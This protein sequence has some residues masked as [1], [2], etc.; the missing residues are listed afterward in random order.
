VSGNPPG[1]RGIFISYRRSD[2]P[3]AAR[4]LKDRLRERFP[5]AAVYFDVDQEPGIDWEARIRE[6]GRN[7]EVFLV[8]IGPRWISELTARSADWRSTGV[9]DV[10]RREIQWAL[11]D[12][13]GV[14]VPV[15]VETGMPNERDLPR[16][17]KGL[18]RK[19]AVVNIRH[20]TFDND[21]DRLLA[22]LEQLS[23]A[24]G[25]ARL[26]ARDGSGEALGGEPS[27]TP[28]RGAAGVPVPSDDHYFEVVGEMTN[29]MVVPLLGASVRGAPPDSCFLAQ[30]LADQFAELRLQSSDL[31]EIAQSIAMMKSDR[32]LRTKLR[33]LIERYSEPIDVHRFLACFPGLFRRGGLPAPYQ[34]IIST[35]YDR[36]LERAFEAVDEPFEYVIY[37]PTSGRFVHFPWGED[38]DEP[39][40]ITIDDPG[41]YFGFEMGENFE[42]QRTLIV[43]LHG[44]P[45]FWEA[46]RE[47]PDDY[48]VTE[49]QYIDYL[50]TAIAGAHLPAEI[51]EKLTGSRC[52][53]LG[54]TLREW[55]TRV[56]LRR[57]WQGMQIRENSWVIEDTPDEL[58]KRSWGAIPRVELFDAHPSEYVGRLSSA[59]DVRLGTVTP[60]GIAG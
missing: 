42:L 49:D 47:W 33:E 44:A 24:G 21:V 29:G 54:Y 6:R 1:P 36:A 43:K 30:Q 34:L 51:L 15:L 57:I 17:I 5:A 60:A 50:P 2:V 13:P 23:V 41:N 35:N 26:D 4:S 11:R 40:A 12:W 22:Q 46:K 19:Q 53:F 59:L 52:L 45:N 27:V 32:Q 25:E 7:A 16:S 55:S 18:C 37:M 28:R 9:I 20:A 10:V 56:L 38:D 39:R 48:V 58:E 8:V 14:V 3:D 31:A